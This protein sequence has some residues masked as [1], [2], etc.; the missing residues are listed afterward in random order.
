MNVNDDINNG[1][2]NTPASGLL[3][4]NLY[5]TSNATMGL[6]NSA[7]I[8]NVAGK[9]IV[10]FQRLNNVSQFGIPTGSINQPGSETAS[11]PYSP[12]E[13]YYPLADVRWWLPLSK[14]SRENFIRIFFPHSHPPSLTH[15]IKQM[16]PCLELI[17]HY[18]SLV[19]QFF[20][21]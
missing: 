13:D 4:N 2:E 20:S 11:L 8:S 9:E 5:A 17:P 3:V 15:K 19:R 14:F 7:A 10:I 6:N 1:G 18:S 16:I 21:Q 12:F